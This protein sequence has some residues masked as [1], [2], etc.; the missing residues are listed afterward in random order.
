M[1]INYIKTY[2]LIFNVFSVLHLDKQFCFSVVKWALSDFAAFFKI[3]RQRL[4]LTP[5]N[6]AKSYNTAKFNNCRIA[7]FRRISYK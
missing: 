4:E 2:I 3:I 5:N 1:I 6:P 7:I